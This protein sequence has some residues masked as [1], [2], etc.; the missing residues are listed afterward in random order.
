LLRLGSGRLLLAFNNS[1]TSRTPLNVALAEEDEHWGWIQTL[2]DGAGEFSY[3]TLA[4]T[5]DGQIHIVYT[6]RREHIQYA[7]FTEAWLRKGKLR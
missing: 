2:E 5:D 1:K 3:P 7:C 6:F 4:Q